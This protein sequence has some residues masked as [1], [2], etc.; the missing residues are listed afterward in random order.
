[1]KKVVLVGLG[2]AHLHV[3]TRTADFA[4]AGAELVLID[5]GDFWYSGLATGLLSGNA[6]PE[7]DRIGAKAFASACGARL[8][9][10]GA[11]EL[12]PQKRHLVLEGGDTL[13]YDVVSFNTGS[14]VSTPFPVDGT[15]W[16][17]KPIK[18][19]WA[20]AQRLEGSSDARSLAVIGGGVTGCELMSNISARF[21]D[22]LALT[23]VS[24]ADRLMD[25]WPKGAGRAMQRL[26]EERGVKLKLGSGVRSIS[27]EQIALENGE[28][29]AADMVLLATG[30]AATPLMAQLG[31]PFDDLHGLRVTSELHSVANE[32]VFA[33]G[34]C[35][36][37]AGRELPKIGVF[38][39]RAAPVLAHNLLAR[40]KG[41]RLR[42]F[43]PQS[44]WFSALNLGDGT[45]L[46][47][48]GP[49][50]W[51]G[52]SALWLK[53]RFDYGFMRRY[54]K[55]ARCEGQTR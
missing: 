10:G 12:D 37:I 32:N 44:V 24:G 5:P 43:R 23:L 42:Q 36:E 30:L 29:V 31:L 17:A 27:A 6:R 50:W 15:V 20:L 7:D 14:V 33:V 51:Q 35:A 26:F 4:R 46:A 22:G 9:K 47:S 13:D 25:G 41:G 52:K 16:R 19:L 1:M 38:G 48:W 55:I 3:L 34:D 21:G 39:V 28:V 8:I 49:I 53:N 18:G 45:G 2:H 54:Q 11:V 40:V